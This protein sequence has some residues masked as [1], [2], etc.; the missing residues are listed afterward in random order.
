MEAT[1]EELKIG[2]YVCHCGTNIAKMVEV[3]NVAKEVS[4]QPGV[5]VARSYKYMCSNPGQ[6]MIAQD[7]KD[8]KLNR[9]VVAACSPRMHEPTFRKALETAGVNP[10]L[11]EMANIR[12]QCS[13]VHEDKAEC[14]AKAKALAKAAVNR[15]RF[16][17]PLEKRSV[18]MCASTLVLGGG[19]AGLTTALELAEGEQQVYLVERTDRL[20]G[21]VARVD[22]TAP[23]LDSAR[24]LL[25]ERTTRVT[26]H[27]RI[28]VM[29]ETELIELGGYV[30]NFRP[31]VKNKQGQVTELEVGAVVVATG[32]K[33]FDAAKVK[34]YG[35][36]RLPDV[37]TSF[38]LE[39]MLRRGKV[40][41][42]A[43]KEPQHVC[44][45]HCVGSRSREHHAYC[46][47]VCCMTG[48]K[49]A[50]EIRSAIPNSRVTDLY[51]DMHAFGKGCEDFYKKSAEIKTMFLM[52]KKNDQPEIRAADPQKDG[53]GMLISVHEQL[54]GEQL[55]IPADMVVL[56]VGMEPRDDSKA[57]AHLVNISRDKDGW[58]IESH[59]K[60]DPVATTTDGV[61]IAGACQSPKDIP[62]SVA[63]AR[64]A[65][66]RILGK[67]AV[68]KL[69]VDAVYA[70]VDEERCSGCRM[71]NEL[72]PYTAIEYNVETK[73]SHVVSAVCKACGCC[74][75]ACPS[76]AI[77]GRH[78]TDKQ[79]FAQ[80]EG[81]L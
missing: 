38:E 80:I 9:V 14:T 27:P 73:R 15:V 1:V 57:V 13:W 53:C 36:G 29:L 72:C 25:T 78:F 63:Q 35:Y 28:K 26:R 44:I 76:G 77:K 6:E 51:I 64:A 46:S 34:A 58:F 8:Q 41:T 3:D 49:Y 69:W 12:E 32:Y 52:Y 81:V 68:G 5:T 19:I 37:V 70:E 65:S 67:I 66:A 17:E 31:K 20:G 56:M 30:G 40:L 55:E 4:T 18:P 42:K 2:F 22:L 48:L 7:I 47:R 10:Y 75:A 59:P 24:D 23:H 45:I 54:S 11:F 39:A 61:F 50:N 43:G 60:L 71:C 33:E 16:H 79:I 21:N 74:V 62:D